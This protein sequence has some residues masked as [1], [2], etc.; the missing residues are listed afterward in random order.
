MFRDATLADGVLERN[1][2]LAEFPS[3]AE[4]WARY[5]RWKGWSPEV[6]KVAET[7]YAPAKT[8]R[9]YQLNA[10]NRTVEAIAGGQNRVLL[11]M[12]T[13]TGKTY[14]ESPKILGIAFPIPPLAEQARIE[15]PEHGPHGP[16][17]VRFHGDL[18]AYR[19]PRPS[20][21]AHTT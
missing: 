4:L 1:L 8:P 17:G 15:P 11:V 19:R 20:T 21:T 14:L 7:E 16:G 9:Y 5:C 10:S 18:R 13:G 6:R 3:P 12:A 2:S